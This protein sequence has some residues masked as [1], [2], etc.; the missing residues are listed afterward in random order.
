MFSF[1]FRLVWEFIFI[2]A[3]YLMQKGK[4]ESKNSGTSP[5]RPQQQNQTSSTGGRPNEGKKKVKK[6]E[7]EISDEDDDDEVIQPTSRGKRKLSKASQR[8]NE[9]S[10]EN[11]PSR[12][13]KS[14]QDAEPQGKSETPSTAQVSKSPPRQ[15]TAQVSKSS[16]RQSTAQASKTSPRRSTTTT[17]QKASSPSKRQRE[18][19]E[20]KPEDFFGSSSSS[21]S[22]KKKSRGESEVKKE[23]NADYTPEAGGKDEQATDDVVASRAT[24]QLATQ[25]KKEHQNHADIVISEANKDEDNHAEAKAAAA[26]PRTTKSGAQLPV[27]APQ[28]LSGK[29]FVITGNLPSMERDE[30][31]LVFRIMMNSSY[32]FKYVCVQARDLILS[33]GGRATTSVSKKTNYLVAGT[34][35]ETGQPVEQVHLFIIL[36]FIQ[37]FNGTYF[38][39]LHRVKNTRKRLPSVFLSWLKKTFC[40]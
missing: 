23:S 34:T 24:V 16:P 37:C 5:R 30:V 8:S 13:R 36:Q 27:G 40:L 28:C 33:Y 19:K 39:V 2:M 4:N 29:T 38:G 17:T 10:K 6:E 20:V 18:Q 7:I 25:Q 14:N 35:L 3:L 12:K 32:T 15:S 11:S 26:L 1:G 9:S 22:N 31:S 21:P